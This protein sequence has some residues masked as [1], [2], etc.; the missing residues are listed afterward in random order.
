MSDL[1][2]YAPCPFTRSERERGLVERFNH[3][4]IGLDVKISQIALPMLT[5]TGT[6]EVVQWPFASPHDFVTRH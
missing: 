2:A 1:D 5:P 6:V 4:D 3:S